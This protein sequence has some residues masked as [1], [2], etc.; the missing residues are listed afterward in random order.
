MFSFY[1]LEN[2]SE[3]ALI[4]FLT[5]VV[6]QVMADLVESKCIIIDEVRFTYCFAVQPVEVSGREQHCVI[7]IRK[8]DSMMNWRMRKLFPRSL[9]TSALLSNLLGRPGFFQ[10]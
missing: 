2:P 4:I 1:D 7:T 9:F 8:V 6:D 10:Y 3:E 5:N